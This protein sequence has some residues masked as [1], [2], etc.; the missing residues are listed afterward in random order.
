MVCA[1]KDQGL[2]KYAAKT[3]PQHNRGK[4][5]KLEYRFTEHK[6]RNIGTSAK[7]QSRL[8]EN[9]NSAHVQERIKTNTSRNYK[10]AKGKEK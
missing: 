1:K 5:R 6:N 3:V 9:K 7:T 10:N 8:R 2:T 4:G